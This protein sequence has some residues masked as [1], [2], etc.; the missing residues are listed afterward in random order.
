MSGDKK[1][2]VERHFVLDDFL[3]RQAPQT[4]EEL[5]ERMYKFKVRS[6]IT[7]ASMTDRSDD[8][9][10]HTWDKMMQY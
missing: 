7:I 6:T 4:Q 5:N 1:D 10:R 9:I 2:I 3:P 8:E